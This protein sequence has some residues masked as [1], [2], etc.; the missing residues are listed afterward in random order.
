MEE[1][2]DLDVGLQRATL[3]IGYGTLLAE[4]SHDSLR[5]LQLVPRHAGEQV[6]L[7]LVV[8]SAVPEVGE[9]V[10]LNVATGQDLAPHEVELAV[11][12]QSRHPFVV[13]R[14]HG[15]EVQAVQ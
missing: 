1:L 3:S 14:E 10:S 11:A 8:Q 6:V 5:P 15:A 4:R 12:V 2:Q 7:D 9:R 13:G